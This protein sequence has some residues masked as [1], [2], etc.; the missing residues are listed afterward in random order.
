MGILDLGFVRIRVLHLY[1]LGGKPCGVMDSDLDP[2]KVDNTTG[3]S[4]FH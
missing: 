2:S 1:L 4:L 3:L